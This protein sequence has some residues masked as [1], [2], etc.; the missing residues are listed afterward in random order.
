MTGR[1]E[2]VTFPLQGK[3]VRVPLAYYALG[4]NMTTVILTRGAEHITVQYISALH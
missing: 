2:D 1:G 4:N 3:K